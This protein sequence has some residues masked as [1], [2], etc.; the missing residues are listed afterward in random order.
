MKDKIYLLFI[1]L[2]VGASLLLAILFALNIEK[3]A[4]KKAFIKSEQERL[5]SERIQNK[6]QNEA[7][8]DN[9]ADTLMDLELSEAQ[10]A[11]KMQETE[12]ILKTIAPE[13]SSPEE[14]DKKNKETDA[15]LKNF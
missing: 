4:K 5:I 13:T 12:A 9:T 2:I 15:I 11:E 3:S 14:L 6:M 10:I 1:I 7:D 8:A